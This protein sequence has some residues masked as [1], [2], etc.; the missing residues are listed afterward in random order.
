ML[1]H[2][3]LGLVGAS[4]SSRATELLKKHAAISIDPADLFAAANAASKPR[5]A[6]R[7]KPGSP[8]SVR[9]ALK[10]TAV[11]D[12][13]PAVLT[14]SSITH[15]ELDLRDPP[16]VTSMQPGLSRL[17]HLALSGHVSLDLMNAFGK[18]RS[19]ESIHLAYGCGEFEHTALVRSSGR[20]SPNFL[21]K[22]WSYEIRDRVD[23]LTLF[24]ELI[25]RRAVEFRP[26]RV[27]DDPGEH[28][29][30]A[31]GGED[32]AWKLICRLDS[33]LDAEVALME[34]ETLIKLGLP[35][36]LKTLYIRDLLLSAGSQLPRLVDLFAKCKLDDLAVGKIHLHGPKNELGT[37][38]IGEM[39]PRW[40]EELQVWKTVLGGE[41]ECCEL[42]AD[43]CTMGRREDPWTAVGM[44]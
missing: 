8:L 7:P 1:R 4:D 44:T 3:D 12:V 31:V 43:K 6:F 28:A 16:T 20:I 22:I 29:W 2:L 19:I 5:T 35:K 41:V 11:I 9:I 40:A 42:Q 32:E 18:C 26:S 25:A 30:P 15:L 17:R 37:G 21:N 27:A 33:V 39:E 10:G 13:L 24:G 36:N 38:Y 34:S 23:S 14:A